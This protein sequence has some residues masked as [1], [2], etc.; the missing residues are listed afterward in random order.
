MYLNLKSKS[1]S[2]PLI[3]VSLSDPPIQSKSFP[4]PPR[5]EWPEQIY[6]A[7]LPTMLDHA[8]PYC[9]PN[10]NIKLSICYHLVFICI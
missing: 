2:L 9:W 8:I 4:S 6:F 3:A 5:P 10:R 1:Q 7:C